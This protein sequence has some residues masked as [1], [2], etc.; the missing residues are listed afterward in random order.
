[1]AKKESAEKAVRAT[2]FDLV[3]DPIVISG[4]DADNV[5]IG[6]YVNIPEPAIGILLATGLVV[7]AAGRRRRVS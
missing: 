7:L 3:G 6:T 1:M 5:A 2:P 4:V